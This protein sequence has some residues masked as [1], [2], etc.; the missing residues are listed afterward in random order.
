[1]CYGHFSWMHAC[2]PHPF[3]VPK[4]YRRGY[5][6]PWNWS[7]KQLWATMWMM[8]IEYWFSGR[9]TSVLNNWVISL[10]TKKTK[11]LW[12]LHFVWGGGHSWKW[13]K[14]IQGISSITKQGKIRLCCI[15]KCT[16][17]KSAIINRPRGAWLP[18][19]DWQKC[20]R[21]QNTPNGTKELKYI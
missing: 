16:E 14:L 7:Y 2:V 17:Q 5:Q 12:I 19:G 11:P 3:L 4:E 15:A 1:M 8:E 20:N 18:T 13:P 21:W 9:A 10:G 6:M